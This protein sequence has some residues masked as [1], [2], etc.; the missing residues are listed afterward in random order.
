MNVYKI[1]LWAH[2]LLCEGISAPATLIM[3][4]TIINLCM[5]VLWPKA[6]ASELHS[7]TLND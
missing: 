3:N 1:G 6:R 5:G 7:I 2:K 4:N